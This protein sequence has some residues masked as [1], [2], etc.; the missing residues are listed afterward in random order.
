[1]NNMCLLFLFLQIIK[2][3]LALPG[4]LHVYD[5]DPYLERMTVNHFASARVAYFIRVKIKSI[6]VEVHLN[7]G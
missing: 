7:A 3:A 6:A 5:G 1:M 4:F 2:E